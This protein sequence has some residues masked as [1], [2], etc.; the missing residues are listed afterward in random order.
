MSLKRKASFPAIAIQKRTKRPIDKNIISINQT[1]GTTQVQTT[2]KTIT[3]PATIV[4][5]R[6]ELAF[7]NTSTADN[8]TVS[9]A[10]IVIRQ[11]NTA[12][13]MSISNGGDFYTPEKEVLA[14]G[15]VSLA[16]N[17]A[18]DGPRLVNA[19][20][21]TKTMRRMMGGDILAF[22]QLSTLAASGTAKG[23]IQF[24]LKT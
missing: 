19:S 18:G 2:L 23:A 17:S 13:T 22:V 8:N 21:Q 10:I 15:V 16:D 11:G 3:F 9:W 5:I 4:G 24:F 12:N 20:G 1:L 7:V 14:Y 6:W